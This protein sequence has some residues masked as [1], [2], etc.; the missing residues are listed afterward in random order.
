MKK[1]AFRLE[2]VR[3]VRRMQEESAKLALQQ[4]NGE[5]HRASVAAEERMAE[6]QRLTASTTGSSGVD[7][8]MQRRYFDE[9]A[10]QSVV[11]ARQAHAAAQ[12]SAEARRQVWSEAATKVKALDRLDE[13]RK[14]EYLIE[15][16]RETNQEVDD[17]VTGRFGRTSNGDPR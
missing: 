14:D 6:Y 16:E 12:E 15:Y 3:R 5:V 1:Y 7:S 2:Q 10:G 17:I 8:F 9:L 11:A 4:A 13:R